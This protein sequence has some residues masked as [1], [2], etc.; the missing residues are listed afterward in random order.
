M[1]RSRSDEPLAPRVSSPDLPASLESVAAIDRHD[2]LL[3]VRVGALRGEVDGSFARIAECEIP[4]VDLDSLTLAGASVR[5]VLISGIRATRLIAPNSAWRTVTINGG[6]LATL[7]LSGA[8]LDGV[9]FRG[10]RIDYANLSM[11]T[12][13]DVRFVDCRFGSLDLPEAALTRVTFEGC[14]AHE[15][16]SRGLR[17]QHLD[18]RGL[19]ALSF[20]SPAGLSGATLTTRQVEQHSTPLAMAL[21][22][23]VLE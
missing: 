19:E 6:R 20:T 13:T 22:I 2:D 1:P 23:R 8:E 15:V 10:M 9:E 16:D 12:V 11:S 17:S 3:G 4:D 5:D 21:G 7:E 18:L 14:H